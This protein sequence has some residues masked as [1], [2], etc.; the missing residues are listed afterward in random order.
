LT[1]FNYICNY[2]KVGPSTTQ[3]PPLFID[4]EAVAMPGS[5]FVT[6]N[7]LDG[8]V[9]G[10]RANEDNWRSVGYYFERVT[11]AARRL[12]RCRTPRLSRR[13]KPMKTC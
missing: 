10:Q 2:A 1:A 5:L 6:N 3:K 7:I 4:G 11:I 12:F 8:E 13:A 9:N